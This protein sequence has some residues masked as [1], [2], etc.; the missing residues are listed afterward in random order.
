MAKPTRLATALTAFGAAGLL[1]A[2]ATGPLLKDNSTASARPSGANVGL[3]TRA[4]VALEKG[5]YATAIGFA[6][7]AV[8]ASPDSA[9]FRALLGNA[10]FAGGRL[11]S[12]EAAYRDS[13][14]LQ[15]DQGAVVL[16]L[17]LVSIGQ[18]KNDA[19]LAL[20]QSSQSLLD[21]ADVGLAMALAGRADEAALLLDTAARQTNADARVRQNLA[22]AFALAGDWTQ[23]RTVAE[24]DLAPDQVEARLQQWMAFAKPAR[25]SDQLAALTGITPVA[26]DPGQPVRLALAGNNPRLAESAA[27]TAVAAAP[28][29]VDA[30]P[31]PTYDAPVAPPVEVTAAAP[32][33]PA[34]PEVVPESAP[35]EVTIPAVAIAAAMP[36]V[37][38]API[39][40]AAA[41]IEVASTP[42]AR[43][44]ALTAKAR[45]VS[46]RTAKPGGAVVQL[47][48]FANRANVEHA[49]ARFAAANPALRGYAPTTARFNAG[50][51]MV[52]RLS[53]G[54]FGSSR[55]AQ[56]F[57]AGLKRSGTS[58]FVRSSS[59]DQTVRLALR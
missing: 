3:A 23:A 35:R 6:E 32:A 27:P 36:A 16:K 7:R 21:P 59:G 15:A 48:A 5:D 18:G 46:P 1:S 12:A 47:G 4:I 58:C 28:A 33:V 2:C 40:E 49:W 39:A 45:H 52:Y 56:S 17:A 38:P 51:S 22:L 44:R 31:V 8:E 34:A 20:L 37:A 14:T 11:A 55:E 9:Q 43:P 42:I 57:C 54:G 53:V 10:Y 19:A 29:F 41:P 26:A 24:Q 30:A 50:R 13:L 25:P